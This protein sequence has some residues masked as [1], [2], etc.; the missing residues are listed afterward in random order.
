MTL[1]AAT[2]VAIP[3]ASAASSPYAGTWVVYATQTKLGTSSCGSTVGQEQPQGKLPIA[4]DGTFAAPGV[5]LRIDPA[6]SLTFSVAAHD[7]C[8]A[9]SGTGSCFT[10]RHC[11]GT[12]SAEDG[13]TSTFRLERVSGGPSASATSSDGSTGLVST[14]QSVNVP[15]G[16]SRTVR[17]SDEATLRVN[18]G[19]G[20]VNMAVKAAVASD[21]Y[22]LPEPRPA[23]AGEAGIGRRYFQFE[24]TV[25]SGELQSVAIAMDLRALG[26]PQGA[27]V[28]DVRFH[29]WTGDRWVLLDSASVKGQGEPDLVV[30]DRD[31][32]LDG[33]RA[34]LTVNHLS[35]Y[36]ITLQ[37]L[38][39]PAGASEAPAPSAVVLLVGLAALAGLHRVWNG[40]RQR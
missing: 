35:S 11:N 12:A 15:P 27:D 14:D 17:L 29:Y 39:Q 10:T 32:N 31:V 30:L 4:D 34:T 28:A 16:S 25:T 33:A 38:D 5:L 2:L 26:L 19:A 36:A 13:G 6:G 3:A 9:S 23:V 7:G 24:S 22:S 1:L 40:R 18:P 21:P 20:G 8:P 37:A